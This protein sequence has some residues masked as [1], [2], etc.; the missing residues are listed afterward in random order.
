MSM[1]LTRT[2]AVGIVSLF[3]IRPRERSERL[4]VGRETL[5]EE[6]DGMV[7]L[8]GSSLQAVVVESL[9]E[10]WWEGEVEEQPAAPEAGWVMDDIM[11]V[12]IAKVSARLTCFRYGR[13]GLFQ[14]KRLR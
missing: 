2:G 11:G 1:G 10:E 5:P 7:V 8:R 13:D 14:W 3:E 4:L 12:V 6:V 9:T